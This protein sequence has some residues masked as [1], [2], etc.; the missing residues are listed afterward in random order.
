MPRTGLA[1]GFRSKRNCEDTFANK[2]LNW[3]R[4]VHYLVCS[5]KLKYPLH[6]LKVVFQGQERPRDWIL[7]NAKKWPCQKVQ[8]QKELCGYLCKQKFELEEKFSLLGM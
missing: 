3:K 5:K 6:K 1:G 7:F 4:S 8:N 2:N